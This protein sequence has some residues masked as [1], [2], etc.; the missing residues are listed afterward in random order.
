[1]AVLSVGISGNN[2]SI[3][4]FSAALLFLLVPFVT[5]LS[6]MNIKMS[7][8][9]ALQFV[10]VA[11]IFSV[12]AVVLPLANVIRYTFTLLSLGAMSLVLTRLRDKEYLV[13][14]FRI[15]LCI[16]FGQIVLELIFPETFQD[17]RHMIGHSELSNPAREEQLAFFDRRYYGIFEEPS[18]FAVFSSLMVSFIFLTDRKALIIIFLILGFLVC[19]S[20]GWLMGP[21]LI[22]L[23]QL[24]RFTNFPSR[25]VRLSQVR[26]VIFMMAIFAVLSV[27][28]FPRINEVVLVMQNYDPSVLK[29]SSASVRLIYPAVDFVSVI[30]N[31]EWPLNV[32]CVG[33]GTCNKSSMKIPFLTYMLY[34]GFLGFLAI[35]VMLSLLTKISLPL[36]LTLTFVVSIFVGGGAFTP[37]FHFSLV[38]SIYLIKMIRI[39]NLPDS[40]N[41]RRLKVF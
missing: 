10:L 39:N 9:Q 11:G 8:G 6:D 40:I 14:S 30:S 33:D 29:L 41:S 34:F 2:S 32:G 13:L 38:A 12:V 24:T 5:K 16:L 21:S 19:P 17:I 35:I 22:L 23:A 26:Q 18:Y 27:F 37:F 36:L 3:I 31:G 15:T 28:A 20:P 25:W 7:Q 1:M 4:V